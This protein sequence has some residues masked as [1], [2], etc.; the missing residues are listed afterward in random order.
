MEIITQ[1]LKKDSVKR[2][3]FLLLLALGCYAIRSIFNLVLLTFIITYIIN[4]LQNVI[5]NYLNKIFKV[6]PKIITIALYLFMLVC[7]TVTIIKYIPLLAYESISIINRIAK[8][9]LHFSSPV[10][11]EY[12]TPLLKQFEISKYAQTGINHALVMATTAGKSGLNVILAIILSLFFMLEKSNIVTFIKKF[13]QSKISGFYHYFEL[14]S[15]NFLNSFGKVIQAQLMIAVVN[16]VL[17]LIGLYFLGFPN[18]IALGAMIFILSLIPV[19]GVIISFIPLSLIAFQI[20][21]IMHIVYMVA[22]V[23]IIHAIESY[24][25]NPKFMSDK[26]DI[27]IF[28]TFVILIVSEHFMGV[29]GLLL[30]IPLFIF[31]LDL[32]GVNLSNKPSAT[33]NEP[34]SEKECSNTKDM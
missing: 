20:G 29:W 17:S 31:V 34:L 21:G 18:L 12:L 7:V 6:N 26:T 3:F 28:F 14:F 4:T 23:L 15:K 30:G 22:L 25:L 10:L 32:L 27:P 16:T 11:Q 1:F 13:E 2:T 9:K 5:V 33:S 8:F 19:A 24:F